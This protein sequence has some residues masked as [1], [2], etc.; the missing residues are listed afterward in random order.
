MRVQQIGM[1][2][3]N[4]KK[5]LTTIDNNNFNHINEIGK[6]RF[7]DVN[8]LINNIKS[9]KTSEAATKKEINN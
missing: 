4:L 7:N 2:R 9:N 1:I 5:I 3:T 6:F 8:N